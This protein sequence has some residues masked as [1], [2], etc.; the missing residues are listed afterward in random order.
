MGKI[1]D[2]LGLSVTC[3]IHDGAFM[4]DPEWK[5]LAEEANPPQAD[6]QE[7]AGKERD[8]VGVF[9]IKED[10]VKKVAPRIK[11]IMESVYSL[12]VPL[13]VEVAFGDNWGELEKRKS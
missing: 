2:F 3:L 1:Y 5:M 11:D 8:A 10:S 13:K 12:K 7:K 9:E 6:A 4:Y